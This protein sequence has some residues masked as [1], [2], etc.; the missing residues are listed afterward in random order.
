MMSLNADTEEEI[1]VTIQSFNKTENKISLCYP[2]KEANPWLSLVNSYHI[3]DIVTCKVVKFAPFGAF[4]EI[5]KGLEGL[6]H[7]SEITYLKRVTKP[8]EVLTIGQ[9]INAKI[10]NIDKEKCKIGLTMKELEGTTKEYGYEAYI[11]G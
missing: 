1:K 6:V 2:D 7:N 5:K 9:T 11:K 4:V 10:I 8:E 3:G